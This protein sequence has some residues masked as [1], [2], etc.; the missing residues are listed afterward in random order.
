MTIGKQMKD[1][2]TLIEQSSVMNYF[3][4]AVICTEKLHWRYT[5]K[6]NLWLEVQLD[7]EPIL[8]NI[9]QQK[10][11]IAGK[12]N[13]WKKSKLSLATKLKF[14]GLRLT[15]CAIMDFFLLPACSS[16]M[17]SVNISKQA[18]RPSVLQTFSL[19]AVKPNK[20]IINPFKCDNLLTRSVLN[21]FRPYVVRPHQAYHCKGNYN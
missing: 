15:R 8:K 12:K 21:Q 2:D 6:N 18:A 7:Y 14:P 10:K 20:Y 19:W 13:R 16:N 17:F 9:G 1:R 4:T 11:R 5:K 3:N